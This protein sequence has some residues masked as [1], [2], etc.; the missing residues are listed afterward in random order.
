MIRPEH[1]N[2]LKGL[3]QLLNAARKDKIMY[4]NAADKQNLPAFKRFFNKQALLRNQLFNDLSSILSQKGIEVDPLLS[5]RPDIQQYMLTSPN[6]EKKNPFKKVLLAD[7]QL[8][9]SLNEIIGL[10]TDENS[11]KKLVQHLQKI[12]AGITESEAY[13]EHLSY[14]VVSA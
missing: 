14:S 3:E 10:E 2:L 4:L 9:D 8:L 7:R 5:R 12:K 11:E 1:K 13:N 6:R